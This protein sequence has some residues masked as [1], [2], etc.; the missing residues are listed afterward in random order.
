M[1]HIFHK[2]RM[3]ENRDGQWHV[4]I[5]GANGEIVLMSENYQ[6]EEHAK[7]VAEAV[8]TEVS[9]VERVPYE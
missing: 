3:V 6:N 4:V 8:G 7:T 2:A 9:E 1:A 5:L